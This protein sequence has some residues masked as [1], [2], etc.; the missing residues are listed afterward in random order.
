MAQQSTPVVPGDKS[1]RCGQQ[2]AGSRRLMEPCG[3]KSSSG[4][5]LFSDGSPPFRRQRE[6]R[7]TCQLPGGN[8]TVQSAGRSWHN[9]VSR[10]SPTLQQGRAHSATGRQFKAS[11]TKCNWSTRS[12]FGRLRV[13]FRPRLS[14]P[15]VRQVH[16]ISH[17]STIDKSQTTASSVRMIALYLNEFFIWHAYCFLSSANTS[18]TDDSRAENCRHVTAVPPGLRRM[19]EK[20]GPYSRRSCRA[21][22]AQA[23]LP[24][25]SRA[26]GNSATPNGS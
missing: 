19:Q 9:I 6:M 14:C 13:T 25:L 26:D 24:W 17:C 10:R 3:A 4:S 2:G 23:L 20:E 5:F 8:S 16:V 11:T 22:T 12:F 21:K 1:T 7:E 18:R 15:A